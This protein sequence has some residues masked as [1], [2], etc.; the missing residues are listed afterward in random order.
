MKNL[1]HNTKQQSDISAAQNDARSESGRSMVEMIGILGII[2]LLTVSGIYLIPLTMRKHNTDLFHEDIM[3]RAIVETAHLS[4][5]GKKAAIEFEEKSRAGDLPIT[6]DKKEKYVDYKV[7]NVPKALCESLLKEDWIHKNV[8]AK[9]VA[10]GNTTYNVVDGKIQDATNDDC[11]ESSE[12]LFRFAKQG[13]L[14]IP[15]PAGGAGG[16]NAQP[17][18]NG[19]VGTCD[20]IPN[21]LTYDA[22]CKCTICDTTVSRLEAGE[23]PCDGDTSAWDEENNRCVE[24]TSN[25]YCT[26][27]NNPKCDTFT[28]EC[29]AC[30]PNSVW[31]GDDCKCNP[32]YYLNKSNGTCQECELGTA[33]KSTSGNSPC[34]PCPDNATCPTTTTFECEAGYQVTAD[35]LG[36][37]LTPCEPAED[38]YRNEAEV[39]IDCP[40][41]ATCDGENFTCNA[42]YVL[43]EAKDGC[44]PCAAG[45][46]AVR[47]ALQCTSCEAGTYSAEAAGQCTDCAAGTYSDEGAT[48]CT[49]CEA[50]T[51]SGDKAAEC[52]PCAENTYSGTKAAECKACDAGYQATKDKTGCE[53]ISCTPPTSFYRNEAKICTPCPVNAT[54]DGENFTCNEGYRVNTLGIACILIRCSTEEYR[55]NFM[56]TPCPDNAACDGEN[57]TCN[58]GYILNATQDGCTP[59]AAGTYAVRGALQC[60]SCE[61]GTYSA[62][63]A[64]QCTDCAAGTYSDEGATTC[65]PCEAGTYSG[66][67]AAECTPC[68]D[69]TPVSP[70]GSTTCYTCQNTATGTEK[71]AGCNT[72]G[73]PMCVTTGMTADTP[74]GAYGDKCVQCMSDSNC[75]SNQVCTQNACTCTGLMNG[76]TCTPCPANAICDGTGFTCNAGYTI[77]SA[78]NGCT[79]CGAGTYKASAGNGGCTYCPAGK[80]QPNAGQTACITCTANTYSGT[81][82]GHCEPCPAGTQVNSSKNGCQNCSH[83]YT[84]NTCGCPLGPNGRGGCN[85]C[86]SSNTANCNPA[87]SIRSNGK[88]L[89]TFRGECNTGACGYKCANF[90]KSNCVWTV[91]NNDEK[92]SFQCY[93][94]N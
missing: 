7:Q 51:Y 17:A 82:W 11:S 75:P 44:T 28:K 91:D 81:G 48:T 70:Q 69:P 93:R 56:C 53:L 21:C 42:G 45:T 49:P 66:N 94:Y 78:G 30:T 8:K 74:A 92:Q 77:N 76:T 24:C 25:L 36:C 57:F 3:S 29:V 61:A 90:E 86:T 83:S 73:R 27:M 67:K 71:D 32:G 13:V 89:C 34:T 35:G 31:S 10:I 62:K 41:N 16:G 64:G 26:D 23:C 87:F 80:Y 4:K 40:D 43:N 19:S 14:M 20:E 52:T 46:Y 1:P 50:G 12:F 38:F 2:G 54:C 6:S 33:Y 65:T 47:G 22:A 85:R 15:K 72:A 18:P 39:C 88:Y 55:K 5:H 59:C 79:P 9:Y 60:T 37:R 68:S 63:T 84:A 58:A